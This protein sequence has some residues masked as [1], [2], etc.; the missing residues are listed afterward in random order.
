MATW[1]KLA[2]TMTSSSL[3]RLALWFFLVTFPKVI[4]DALWLHYIDNTAA[5]ASLIR[6]SSSLEHGAVFNMVKDPVE[7]A[8][9]VL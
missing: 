5:E 2:P 9:G 7:Q 3:R 4:K 1:T 8:L 6:G